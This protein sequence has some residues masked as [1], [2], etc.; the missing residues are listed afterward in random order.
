[1]REQRALWADLLNSARELAGQG[2][3]DA[4]SSVLRVAKLGRLRTAAAKS[5][6]AELRSVARARSLSPTSMRR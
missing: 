1:L 5:L 2:E 6:K 3:S 4:A